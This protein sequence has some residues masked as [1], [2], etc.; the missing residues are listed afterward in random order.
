MQRDNSRG[1]SFWSQKF[2]WL[3]WLPSAMLV[4]VAGMQCM[5]VTT[6]GLVPWKGG[7]FGMFSSVDSPSSRRFSFHGDDDQG[8]SYRLNVAFTDSLDLYLRCYP[9]GQSIHA[10]ATE[11]VNK[12]WVSDGKLYE[13]FLDRADRQSLGPGI[14]YQPAAGTTPRI[15]Q[16]LEDE[17]TVPHATDAIQLASVQVQLWR[18]AF[19]SSRGKVRWE[20]VGLPIEVKREL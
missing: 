3:I 16:Q 13:D 7:G 4:I 11:L 10:L 6:R 2:R 12:I 20:P 9:D 8:N 15:L 1:N 17:R 5:L 18:F 19:D 14:H